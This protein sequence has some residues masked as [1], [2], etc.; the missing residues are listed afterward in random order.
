MSSRKQSLWMYRIRFCGSTYVHHLKVKEQEES[1]TKK[2]KTEN[3]DWKRIVRMSSLI[4]CNHPTI[5]HMSLIA[6]HVKPKQANEMA[7]DSTRWKANWKSPPVTL[8]KSPIPDLLFYYLVGNISKM[9][10]H[11]RF[12]WL[13]SKNVSKCLL[14]NTC[15]QDFTF[16]CYYWARQKGLGALRYINT[17]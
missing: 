9:H 5:W 1:Q 4:R 13:M 17:L 16:K 11:T 3:W 6:L 12:K 14:L 10:C 7:I 15:Y 8:F 2:N